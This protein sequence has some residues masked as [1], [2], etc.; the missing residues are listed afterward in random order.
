MQVRVTSQVTGLLPCRGIR[1]S[2]SGR[3][4]A[5]KSGETDRLFVDGNVGRGD[6]TCNGLMPCYSAYTTNHESP[7]HLLQRHIGLVS[8]VAGEDGK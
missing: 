8:D 1:V 7:L 4:L 5:V 2:P 3:P 6:D